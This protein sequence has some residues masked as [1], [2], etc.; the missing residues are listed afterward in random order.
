MSGKPRPDALLLRIPLIVGAV[1][2]G[3][4]ILGRLFAAMEAVEAG[5]TIVMSI[6]SGGVATIIKT[7]V[8]SVTKQVILD[9]VLGAVFATT[10]SSA[11]VTAIGTFDESVLEALPGRILQGFVG[12][13]TILG[14]AVTAGQSVRGSARHRPQEVVFLCG[15]GADGIAAR[16]LGKFCPEN[17]S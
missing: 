16:T 8:A 14:A 6:L 4:T 11:I 12:G 5:L 1:V 10:L 13:I 17:P 7:V 2:S 9:A 15:V 3:K